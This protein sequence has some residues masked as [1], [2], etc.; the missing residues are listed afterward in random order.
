MERDDFQALLEV[1]GAAQ[2]IFWREFLYPVRRPMRKRSAG[3][4]LAA[5]GTVGRGCQRPAASLADN[6]NAPKKVA[7]DSSAYCLAAGAWFFRN[8]V[9]S[10][11]GPVGLDA[12]PEWFWS[13]GG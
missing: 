8:S 10:G 2:M 12:A 7:A 13:I 9:A 1:S 11:S 5:R 3:L 6:T 4:Q